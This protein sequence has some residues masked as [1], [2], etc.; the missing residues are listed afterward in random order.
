MKDP[1][2]GKP[3]TKHTPKDDVR[4]LDREVDQIAPKAAAHSIDALLAEAL[5]TA[6]I[7]EG[8]HRRN[9]I[10]ILERVRDHYVD[11]DFSEA[12]H[13]E[14]RLKRERSAFRPDTF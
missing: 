6:N 10:N 9:E 5:H 7:P 2:R 14:N 13:K 1:F 11:E 12:A 4:A 3:I 8:P